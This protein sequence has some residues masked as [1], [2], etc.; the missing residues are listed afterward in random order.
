MNLPLV[1]RWFGQPFPDDEPSAGSCTYAEAVALVD[2]TWVDCDD[3]PVTGEVV[4]RVSGN[5]TPF[6]DMFWEHTE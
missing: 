4:R 6:L 5:G 1:V 2:E 3:R